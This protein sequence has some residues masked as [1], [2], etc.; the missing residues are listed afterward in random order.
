MI[1]EL[2]TLIY[3]LSSDSKLVIDFVKKGLLINLIHM[4]TS[5]D[6][7]INVNCAQ[8]LANMCRVEQAH[9]KIIDS[10]API[11]LIE[12]LER[13]KLNEQYHSAV[14]WVLA[15]LI[16]TSSKLKK[17]MLIRF[18]TNFFLKALTHL[19]GAQTKQ[20]QLASVWR[21]VCVCVCVCVY[22]CVC[23]CMDVCV[24]VFCPWVTE[25]VAKPLPPYL[26][27]SM[28]HTQNNK[29]IH[30]HIHE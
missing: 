3:Y 5:D 19:M 7:I 11:R 24:C 23:V 21:C 6:K 20:L 17:K 12:T 29:H 2:S 14:A 30:T 9:E 4:L 8:T 26:C 25:P 10:D 18:G 13:I 16:S 1:K 22:V 28:H 27:V 15:S